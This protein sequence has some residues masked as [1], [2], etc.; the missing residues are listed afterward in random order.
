M[1]VYHAGD[2]K[3]D[4]WDVNSDDIRDWRIHLVVECV[5]RANCWE[6]CPWPP[7]FSSE[8]QS[9]APTLSVFNAPVEGDLV[10]ILPR[11]S[12]WENEQML[13]KNLMLG[14][15]VLTEWTS[16]TDRQRLDWQNCYNRPV[17]SFF[18]DPLP[19]FPF[20]LPFF[21]SPFPS[22]FP[23]PFSLPFPSFPCP[24]P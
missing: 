3:D 9:K 13:E 24:Y 16:V 17:T 8:R 6:N 7:T 23:F 19:S 21:P 14:S 2:P 10:G 20:S 4:H 15:A 12:V 1:D 22:S 18:I 5:R 11:W